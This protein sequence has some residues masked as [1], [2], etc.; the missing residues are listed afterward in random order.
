MNDD[1]ALHSMLKAAVG[2]VRH[3]S[4]TCR[5]GRADDPM[6]VTDEAGL[7]RRAR[8]G[9][10][11]SGRCPDQTLVR[12]GSSMR[13]T[14]YSAGLAS[15]LLAGLAAAIAVNTTSALRSSSSI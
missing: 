13:I 3:A 4:G 11:C 8:S 5:M 6:A 14:A 1:R 9:G 12:H 15:T 10:A 7:V 2:G